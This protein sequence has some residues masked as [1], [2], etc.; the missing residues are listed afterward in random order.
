VP[1]AA[2]DH[3]L[4]GHG[5]HIGAARRAASHHAGDLRDALRAHIGLIEEDPPEMV[6][7]GEDLGLMGQ[8][9]AA[10]ESTR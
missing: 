2:H 4:I 3:R 5:R 1:C 7:I 9:R 10:A 6:A 8:I